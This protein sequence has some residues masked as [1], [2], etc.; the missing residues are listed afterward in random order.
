MFNKWK[1]TDQKKGSRK[2]LY[3]SKKGLNFIE[4][5]T[6]RLCGERGIRTPG[7]LTRSTVFKTAAFDHSAISPNAVAKVVHFFNLQSQ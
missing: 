1:E 5:Q 3:K 4:I 2:I 7:P 6:F